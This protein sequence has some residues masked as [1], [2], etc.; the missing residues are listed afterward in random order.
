MNSYAGE[1]ILKIHNINQRS[2]YKEAILVL[3]NFV[4]DVGYLFCASIK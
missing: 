3:L 4:Q 1:F 2:F